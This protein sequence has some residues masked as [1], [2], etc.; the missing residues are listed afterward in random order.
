MGTRS[1]NR[2]K[3]VLAD[4]QKTGKELATYLGMSEQ[5]VSKWVTNAS[6]PSLEMLYNIAKYLRVSVCE[7]LV[8]PT[9]FKEN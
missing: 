4:K 6:Q 8:S 1:Y 5:M 7:L 2:I 3:A 9:M